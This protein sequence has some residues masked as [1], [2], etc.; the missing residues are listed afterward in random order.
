MVPLLQLILVLEQRL[1][2]LLQLLVRLLDADG[3]PLQ[4]IVK[5]MELGELFLFFLG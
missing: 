5:G 1:Q 2:L 3:L 4:R